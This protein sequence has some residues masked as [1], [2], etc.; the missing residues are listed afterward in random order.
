MM[1]THN[2]LA[3]EYLRQKQYKQAYIHQQHYIEMKLA[4]M[5]TKRND[6]INALQAKFDYTKQQQEIEVLN[7]NN[8]LQQSK[9]TQKRMYEVL[10]ICTAVILLTIAIIVLRRNIGLEKRFTR[11][12]GKNKKLYQDC[13]Y[14][15]LTSL[16]NRRYLDE[17]LNS[18]L[19]QSTHYALIAL[20][21]DH[22]KEVNDN[23]GHDYGDEVLKAIAKI[24]KNSLRDNDLVFSLWWRRVHLITCY[25]ASEN[26]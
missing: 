4:Q 18:F 13:F 3:K 21:I 14:D 5:D 23:Y 9:L 25:R 17:T 7:L 6:K 12:L 11:I 16:Y 1:H 26:S 24:L 15:Q 8:S 19:G 10:W 22:F 20:D 2:Y